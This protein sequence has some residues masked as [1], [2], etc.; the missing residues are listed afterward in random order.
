MALLALLAPACG[1]PARSRPTAVQELRLIAAVELA[2]H[3][4]TGRYGEPAELQKAGYL[5][6]QWP[7]S[8]GGGHTISCEIAAAGAGFACYADP[9]RP[10]GQPYL[11]VD[12][13]QA[14]RREADRR[15]G[16][17]SEKLPDSP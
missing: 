17:A 14:V 6:P 4:S 3:A 2:F 16:A 11:R 5:D 13:T 8:Q 10:G 15:P 12:A 9:V 1:R 7:R